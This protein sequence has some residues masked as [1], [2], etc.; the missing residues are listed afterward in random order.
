MTQFRSWEGREDSDIVVYVKDYMLVFKLLSVYGKA[1]EGGSGEGAA[2]TSTVVAP[3]KL[4]APNSSHEPRFSPA[5]YSITVQSCGQTH[6]F[7]EHI[8]TIGEEGEGLKKM[9]FDVSANFGLNIWAL[10]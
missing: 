1:G 7:S 6:S 8:W 9:T 3:G 10:M 4:F 5:Q 2:V